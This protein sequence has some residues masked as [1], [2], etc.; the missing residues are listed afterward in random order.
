MELYIPIRLNENQANLY[1]TLCQVGMD[2]SFNTYTFH[3]YYVTGTVP[4]PWD[5]G[6]THTY[7]DP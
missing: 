3:A 1:L 2:Y 6:V 4:G 5:T 7:K